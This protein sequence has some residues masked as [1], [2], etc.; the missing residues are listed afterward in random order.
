LHFFLS[1][2]FLISIPFWE[3]K[4]ASDWEFPNGEVRSYQNKSKKKPEQSQAIFD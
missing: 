3:T 4:N 1:F 2:L